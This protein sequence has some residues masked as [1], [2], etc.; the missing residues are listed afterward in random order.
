MSGDLSAL[1]WLLKL[2]ALV[3]LYLLVDTLRLP[4]ALDPN[5]A[6][7]AWI[8]FT[9]SAYRCLFPNRYADNVV[10]H[11]TRFSSTGVTRLLATFVEVS[12]IYQFSYVLRLLNQNGTGWVDALSW[13]MVVQV[14]VSQGFVWGA[15]ATGRLRLYVYEEI[16]WALI[17][18]ANTIASGF[19]Y[20]TTQPGEGGV[21]LLQLNLLFGFFYLPWQLLHL[22]TLRSE[23]TASGDA[24]EIEREAVSARL[25]A[26]FTDTRRRTDAAAWG[27]LVG[28]TWMTAYWASL[29]PVWVHRVAVVVSSGL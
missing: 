28:V 21:L 8:L 25:R 20:A 7:P 3:N 16:G 18:L 6:V 23:A 26:A 27:G 2:G 9:V 5:V 15:I 1:L 12:W 13:A 11:A 14:V 19:L 24:T 4:G 22:S 29:I 10:F 17:F